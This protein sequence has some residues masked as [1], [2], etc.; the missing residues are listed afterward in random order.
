MACE[1]HWPL[2]AATRSTPTGA[3]A[4]GGLLGGVEVRHTRRGTWRKQGAKGR[5]S[6]A[7]RASCRAA[8]KPGGLAR[9]RDIAGAKPTVPRMHGMR[10]VP[11]NARYGSRFA[12]RVDR[13][14]GSPMSAI[15]VK[16][17][18]RGLGDGARSRGWDLSGGRGGAPVRSPLGSG[19]S[20][21]SNSANTG[22]DGGATDA[23]SSSSSGGSGSGGSSG[24]SSGVDS[25]SS[26]GIDSGSSS[27]VDSG[28]DGA[29]D[30]GD[31][32]PQDR[33]AALQAAPG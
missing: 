23:T 15:E 12:S 25:G 30:G 9:S 26:G 7:A 29:P 13:G 11:S 17:R 3:P 14:T 32:G 31:G 4:A 24:S 27:G 18:C 22:S 10:C 19:C 8:G 16:S 6:E 5:E 33:R 28:T 2:P 21:S 1:S 20:S